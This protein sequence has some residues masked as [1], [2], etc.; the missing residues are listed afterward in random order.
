MKLLP[1]QCLPDLFPS[2]R[3]AMLVS[4][5]PRRMKRERQE[6]MDFI[7]TIFQ[8]HHQSRAAGGAEEDLLDVLLRIQ[9]QDKTNPALTN[10]NIKTV[11]I[12]KPS[13]SRSATTSPLQNK[14]KN[15]D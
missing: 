8:E 6:M 14:K 2:S 3:A 4:R 15:Q 7:D 5:M 13:S 12:V 10:D 11:I 9:S 1:A